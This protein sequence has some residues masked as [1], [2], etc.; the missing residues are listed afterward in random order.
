VARLVDVQELR[1][2]D[3]GISDRGHVA[4]VAAESFVHLL[5]DAL[6]LQRHGVEVRLAQ[7]RAFALAALGRPC[8]PVLEPARRG[9]PGRDFDEQGQGGPGI[10]HDAV[11][12][13]E[14]PA[15]LGRLDVDVDELA[16]LRVGLD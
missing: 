7:H 14:H 5:V 4:S 13:R 9:P 8:A 10:R 1:A 2:G 3:L 6:R 16:A 11:I 12:R 15:D